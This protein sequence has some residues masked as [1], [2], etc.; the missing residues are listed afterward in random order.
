MGVI[1]LFFKKPDTKKLNNEEYDTEFSD[2][3]A[4]TYAMEQEQPP[5][6]Y[7]PPLNPGNIPPHNPYSANGINIEV[8]PARITLFYNGILAK[9]GA[10]EVIAV[11]GHGENSRW[12]D[13]KE[14]PMWYAGNQTF[15]LY[16]PP[17][18]AKSI[19]IAFK[20]SAGNWD[21]NSGRN[22]TFNNLIG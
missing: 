19:N 21:N 22:Y 15:V 10:K 4:Y 17:D 13:V 9:D 11:V 18:K 20:D 6:P 2:A 7:V 16:L 8:T 12:E 14:Y 5:E 1:D 3:D